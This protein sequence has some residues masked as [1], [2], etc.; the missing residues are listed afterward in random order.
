L[1]AELLWVDVGH[2]EIEDESVDEL[3][4]NL[5]SADLAGDA[6]EVRAYGDAIRQAYQ[7]L[8]RA[9]AQADLIMSIAG[10]LSEANLGDNPKDNIRKIL[11]ARTAQLLNA[12]NETGKGAE[13]AKE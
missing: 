13:Q 12:M 9:E 1:G 6:A 10:A 11:L 5:W 8:G 3:R 7:E 2:I 4:T